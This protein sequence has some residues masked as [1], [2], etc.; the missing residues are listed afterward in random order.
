MSPPS[1]P[2]KSPARSLA[3]FDLFEG[4]Q[5]TERRALEQ[6][7]YWRAWPR[8]GI[9]I[10]RDTLGGSVHF[11]LSGRC[12][13]A[14]R[15]GKRELVLDEIGPGG[16][17]GEIS[18]IDGERRSAVVMA[19]MRTRTAE[20]D[21][22]RFLEFL[23]RHPHAALKV[24]RRLAEVIRQADAALLELSGL[25]AHARICVELL[26]RARVG[27]GLPPNCAV[28]SPPPKHA[29]IAVRAA[30]TRETVARALSLFERR[31]LLLRSE[32]RITI[33]DVA[34]LGRLTAINCEVTS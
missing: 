32:E 10:G 2:P 34:A 1:T 15:F 13:V 4:V 22:E 11:V 23:V 3:G 7:C 9:A 21:G 25:N 14:M 26:R 30:T 6:R 20:L 17:F 29:E 12:R 19:T 8:G 5:E 27:G 24:M 18:A 28:L 33:T 16:F 31:S